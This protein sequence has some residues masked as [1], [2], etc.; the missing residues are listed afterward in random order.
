[1]N[2]LLMTDVRYRFYWSRDLV[3]HTQ[4]ILHNSLHDN[5]VKCESLF[6]MF[7]LGKIKFIGIL[8]K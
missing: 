5:P 3:V 4:I 8:K 2:S 1:M 6:F 7:V